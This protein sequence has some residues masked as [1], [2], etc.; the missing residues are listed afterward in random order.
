M[1]LEEILIEQMEVRTYSEKGK[2]QE[3]F[4]TCMRD[5]VFKYIIQTKPGMKVIKEIFKM[6][7][8]IEIKSVELKNP[9]LKVSDKSIKGKRVDF[10]LNDGDVVLN[11]EVNNTSESN[12]LRNYAYINTLLINDVLESEKYT[13]DTTYYL[14]NFSRKSTLKKLADEYGICSVNS[15]IIV[16]P[17]LKI[18]EIDME[19]VKDMCYDKDV[20]SIDKLYKYIAMLIA[21]E[22]LL[23]K[24][25]KG[26]ELLMEFKKEVELFN[27]KGRFWISP[28]EDEIMWENTIKHNAKKEGER[29]GILK[30]AKNMLIR[31]YDKK[32][33]SEITGLSISQINKINI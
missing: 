1:D 23:E 10:L 13:L 30:T 4:L 17:I 5:K 19:I 20:E 2:E 8:G 25:S 28:E 11:V 18:I 14:L 16:I 32:T 21:D 7:T 33:I 31:G 3:E 9:E 6:I 29:K 27:T 26:D 24:L 12:I 22:E 15:G